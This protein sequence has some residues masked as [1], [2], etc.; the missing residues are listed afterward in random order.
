MYSFFVLGLVPGTNFQI[1]FQ[2]WLDAALLAVAAVACI[3]LYRLEH[4]DRQVEHVIL[5]YA[6]LDAGRLHTRLTLHRRSALSNLTQPVVVIG[7][8]AATLPTR[9]AG[10]VSACQPLILTND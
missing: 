8:T 6:P 9:I 3:A 7:H 4:L 10:F 5:R 2:V 1:T